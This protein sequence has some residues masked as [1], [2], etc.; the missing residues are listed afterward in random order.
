M[1]EAQGLLSP[2]S[3]LMS[4]NCSTVE[5][6]WPRQRSRPRTPGALAKGRRGE[7]REAGA[8]PQDSPRGQQGTPRLVFV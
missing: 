1:E 4:A 7:G 8:G 3:R 2:G 5:K 6:L